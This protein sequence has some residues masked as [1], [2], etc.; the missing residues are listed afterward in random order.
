M[1]HTKNNIHCEHH[2]WD[3]NLKSISNNESLVPYCIIC[4]IEKVQ[5]PAISC[6]SGYT[7][8][9]AVDLKPEPYMYSIKTTFFSISVD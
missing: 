4:R 5:P 9:Y 2:I 1:S 3:V 7:K 8:K 6:E